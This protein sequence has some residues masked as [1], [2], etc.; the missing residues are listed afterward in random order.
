[1]NREQ[2][3]D[4]LGHI[5]TRHVWPEQGDLKMLSLCLVDDDTEEVGLGISVYGDSDLTVLSDALVEALLGEDRRP[6]QWLALT[7][8]VY[9]DEMTEEELAAKT[10][11]LGVAPT[12]TTRHGLM[13][14]AVDPKGMHSTIWQVDLDKVIELPQE[15]IMRSE[16]APGGM[17]A[18]ILVGLFSAL[19]LVGGGH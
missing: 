9:Y 7:S 16:E 13:V 8:T 15:P 6:P 3:A 2:R 1:M 17:N 12:P 18:E 11:N 19:V 5:W 4:L 10:E 14:L